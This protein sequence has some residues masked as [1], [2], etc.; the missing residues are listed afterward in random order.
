MSGGQGSR[1][2]C[3]RAEKRVERQ[4]CGPKSSS[5]KGLLA[6]TASRQRRIVVGR[7]VLVGP[8]CAGSV[9]W[10]RLGVLGVFWAWKTGP[11]VIW[12]PVGDSCG[13]GV[14]YDFGIFDGGGNPDA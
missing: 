10:R 4:V 2:A 12:G 9:G 14:L 7:S 8:R 5:Y 11:A 1:S 6:G 13:I 3:K